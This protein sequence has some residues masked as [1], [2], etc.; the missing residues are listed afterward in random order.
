M[1]IMSK[2]VD[3]ALTEKISVRNL[4]FFYGSTLALN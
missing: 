2:D 1:N 4:K 3:S